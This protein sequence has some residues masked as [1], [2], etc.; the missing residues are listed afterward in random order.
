MGD[1]H[2]HCPKCQGLLLVDDKGMGRKVPCPLCRAT[3][4]IPL[5]SE[6]EATDAP[7]QPA[8]AS[9][10]PAGTTCTR[11]GKKVTDQHGVL[12]AC[13]AAGIELHWGAAGPTLN[14]GAQAAAGLND[15]YELLIH[16]S[17][18]LADA[19]DTSL[20][21]WAPHG[22][23]PKCGELWCHECIVGPLPDRHLH[24]PPH[25]RCA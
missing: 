19:F 16:N 18:E 14:I 9:S 6:P 2:F 10:G 13:Q 24:A 7:A 17:H 1:L 22:R 4:A 25:C 12:D 5:R 8:A 21:A 20:G 11:C 15:I 3:I 23:C